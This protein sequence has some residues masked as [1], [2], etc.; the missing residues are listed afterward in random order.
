LNFPVKNG[1]LAFWDTLGL[2]GLWKVRL[3]A[4]DKSGN[5]SDTSIKLNID[6]E[7]P[8]V[9]IINPKGYSKNKGSI[10]VEWFVYDQYGI[11]KNILQYQDINRS[12]PPI[13][14]YE[15]NETKYNWDTTGLNGKYYLKIVSEDLAENVSSD[16]II[17]N[18]DNTPPIISNLSAYPL[19][20]HPQS[21]LKLT[22]ITFEISEN[23]K[24]TI[25]ILNSSGTMVRNLINSYPYNTGTVTE[26]WNGLDKFG[27]IVPEGIY[28]IKIQAI[29]ESGNCSDIKTISIIISGDIIPPEVKNIT[30]SPDPFSPNN[31]NIKDYITI[32]YNLSDN[33]YSY[34]NT[35]I[36]IYNSIGN[37]VRKLINNVMKLV[38]D[39]QDIGMVKIMKI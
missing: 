22:M 29:D 15:G 31:D 5:V 12:N 37:E 3:S 4:F 1:N 38:G 6:N 24:V 35:T 18:I 25:D 13:I 23:S 2:N 27:K 32:H 36:D 26:I 39:N 11:K 10:N 21:Q 34:I 7:P 16:E 9:Y 30:D 19:I 28:T 33:V 17:I 14:I 8:Y 20:F